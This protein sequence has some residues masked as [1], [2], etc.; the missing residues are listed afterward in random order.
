M[1]IP[2]SYALGCSCWGFHT[3]EKYIIS[4]F[5]GVIQVEATISDSADTGLYT[6][7]VKAITTYKGTTPPES[8]KVAGSKNGDIQRSQ[9]EIK[10]KSGEVWL[11]ALAKNNSDIYKLTRCTF[12]EKIRLTDG[13]ELKNRSAKDAMNHFSFLKGHIPDLYREFSVLENTGNIYKFLR[14][15]EGQSFNKS[16]AHYLLSFNRQ[17]E[18]TNIEVLQGFSSE[19]DEELSEFL[20]S[21]TKWKRA[22]VFGNNEAIT[23]TTKYVLD[24]YHNSGK[25]SLSRTRY[26]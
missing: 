11:V 14:N 19:F 4:N 24:I 20:E 7:K 15:Y 16:S 9:C 3:S 8:I 6:A 21:N 10:V 5:A 17:F 2:V 22:G 1:V 23:S 26:F 12:A 25:K 13:T 18:I